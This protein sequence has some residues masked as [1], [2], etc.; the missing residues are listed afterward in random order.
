MTRIAA[1]DAQAMNQLYHEHVTA[2]LRTAGVNPDKD[3]PF[4]TD[5]AFKDHESYMAALESVLNS[6]DKQA[7][8]PNDPILD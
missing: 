1:S 8:D 2:A 4:N 6:D 7:F 5:V 3:L